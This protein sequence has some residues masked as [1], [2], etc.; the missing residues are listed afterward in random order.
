MIL[1]VITIAALVGYLVLGESYVRLRE[2]CRL[3]YFAALLVLL[4]QYGTYFNSM[5][6]EAIR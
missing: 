2:V 4:L 5:I 3:T 1:L 6:K